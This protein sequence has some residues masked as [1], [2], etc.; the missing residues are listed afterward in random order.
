[1]RFTTAGWPGAFLKQ[2][3]GA[4]FVTEESAYEGSEH[5]SNATIWC[6]GTSEPQRCFAAVRLSSVVDEYR[7]LIG[8]FELVPR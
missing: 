2:H 5:H 3:Y 8:Y 6:V 4:V 7:D 1:V